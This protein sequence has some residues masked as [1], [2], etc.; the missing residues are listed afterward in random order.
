[1]ILNRLGPSEN[2]PD[3]VTALQTF[4]IGDHHVAIVEMIIVLPKAS[5]DL[6]D[7]FDRLLRRQSQCDQHRGWG[8]SN[9][10][11]KV[12]GDGNPCFITLEAGP[13]HSGL[14]SAI[15]LCRAAAA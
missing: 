1:L 2:G 10:G 15:R 6:A 9:I 14:E 11:G 13:T 5:L 4:G 12:I 8:M 7:R 3:R